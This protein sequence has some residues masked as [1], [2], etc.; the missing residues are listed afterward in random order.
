LAC[1]A[2]LSGNSAFAGGWRSLGP[3]GFFGADNGY[4]TSGPQIDAGRVTGVAPSPSGGPLIIS[5]ASGGVWKSTFGVWS[6]LTDGQCALTT[7]AVTVDP[8]DANVIYVGT[9]EYNSNS[10]GCG[11]LRSTDGGASWTQL[12]AST[13]RFTTGGSLI[14]RA[15]PGGSC[16][17]L[18]HRHDEPDCG[19]ERRRLS[20]RRWWRD[21]EL[22]AHR[23]DGER[24]CA[25]D[26]RRRALC[27]QQR[28]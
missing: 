20:L 10:V 9:G 4:F 22:G 18:G 16:G 25:S 24:R 1:C 19:D 7:G 3:Q 21:V 17:W 12:G 5:T 28:Q 26:E 13:F 2:A 11:I 23:R 8:T 6:P 15:P 14:V 27:R